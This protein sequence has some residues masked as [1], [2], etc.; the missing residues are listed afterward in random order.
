MRTAASRATG[1]GTNTPSDTR[2][3]TTP[4]S[5]SSPPTIFATLRSCSACSPPTPH[6][7]RASRAVSRPTPGLSSPTARTR[8]ARSR[9]TTSTTP[10]SCVTRRKRSS[11]RM[12]WRSHRTAA[13]CRCMPKV[14]LHARWRPRGGYCPAWLS[15]RYT[16][17]ASSMGVLA[18]WRRHAAYAG[19][20]KH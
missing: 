2:I 9:R 11:G 3:S 18:D 19:G 15:R 17:S 13:T 16:G 12:W 8:A 7:P 6:T 4:P 5:A 14:R 10:L 20:G 1:A